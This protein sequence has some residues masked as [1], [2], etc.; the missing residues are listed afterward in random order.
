MAETTSCEIC[1]VEIEGE[2]FTLSALTEPPSMLEACETCASSPYITVRHDGL[3]IRIDRDDY[4]RA[5]HERLHVGL[6][7]ISE[8]MS[9]LGWTL[10]A[11]RVHARSD[12]ATEP[13]YE[14]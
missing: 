14:E 3:Q 10:E 13:Y 5:D 4:I 6:D 9:Y 12:R 11:V 1:G 7:K 8:E 2:P